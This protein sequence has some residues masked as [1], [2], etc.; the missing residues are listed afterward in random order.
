[1]AA[2]HRL[3]YIDTLKGI[4][5]ILVVLGHLI[6]FFWCPENYRGNIAFNYIYSFHM[7]FFMMLS[8]FTVKTFH[9]S[10][11]ELAFVIFKRSINLL[12]PFFCWAVIKWQ[13]FHGPNI[14]A[15]MQNTELGLWF[16]HAL[17]FIYSIFIIAM[18]PMKGKGKILKYA[19]LLIVCMTIRKAFDEISYV[20]STVKIAT[21]FSSFCL[22]YILADNK[23]WLFK[24]EQVK[25]FGFAL[26]IF[27]IL[28]YFS[29]SSEINLPA[30]IT[31]FQMSLFY[32]LIIVLMAALP[33]IG[34]S[35]YF[36]K[37]FKIAG[38]G[39]I[40]KTT[41]GIYAIHPFLIGWLKH[42][43]LGIRHFLSETIGG[44]DFCVLLCSYNVCVN[45]KMLRKE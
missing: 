12:L 25:Y 2:N 24:K 16:L 44:G 30:F 19:W 35:L 6:Q 33:L 41:L 8:G 32:Q 3:D 11:Q 31:K 29:F 7:G 42:L 39:N 36:P 15:V 9:D 4:A 14:I 17:F 27:L 37:F 28:A 20:W 38:F 45:C 18:Y 40:G 21:Y 13:V 22:G 23:E 1:M 5:I 10:Y 34:V 43:P 26:P